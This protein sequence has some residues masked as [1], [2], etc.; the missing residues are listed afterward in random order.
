MVRIQCRNGGCL[1][2]YREES[3]GTDYTHIA[4]CLTLQYYY[5][6]TYLQLNGYY[7]RRTCQYEDECIKAI[8]SQYLMSQQLSLNILTFSLN[9][10]KLRYGKR[11]V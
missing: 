11:R 6:L 3:D 10:N 4:L 5:L 8:A 1:K 2:L 9:I 7:C